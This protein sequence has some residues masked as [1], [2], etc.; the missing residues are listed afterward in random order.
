[1]TQM[2]LGVE[3][4]NGDKCPKCG[5]RDSVLLRSLLSLC[6]KCGNRWL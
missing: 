6:R 1:M 4:E 2:S 3:N 5:S